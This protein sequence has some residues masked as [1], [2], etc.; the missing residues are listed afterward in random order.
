MESL[1]EWTKKVLSLPTDKSTVQRLAVCY[2][3]LCDEENF[4]AL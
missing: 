1:L 2:L 4:S 3:A